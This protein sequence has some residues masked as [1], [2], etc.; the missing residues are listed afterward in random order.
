MPPT[1]NRTDPAYARNRDSPIDW[2]PS[3]SARP[4][5]C[6]DPVQQRRTRR[7]RACARPQA[8][9]AAPHAAA[10]WRAARDAAPAL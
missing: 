3:A 4:S 5:C 2:T 6:S 1:V 7:P 10:R 8:G 9:A